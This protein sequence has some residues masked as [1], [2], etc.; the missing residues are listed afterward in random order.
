MYLHA[1]KFTPWPSLLF[2]HHD[3]IDVEVCAGRAR[4]VQ[5]ADLDLAGSRRVGCE[6][7]HLNVLKIQLDSVCVAVVG[8]EVDTL[9]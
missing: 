2:D 9:V 1:Q 6:L 7:P 8:A 5:D 4:P 3:I